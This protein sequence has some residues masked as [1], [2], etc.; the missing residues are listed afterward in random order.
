MG[1]WKL[2]RRHTVR[3][4][5]RKIVETLGG[6]LVGKAFGTFQFHHQRVVDKEIREILSHRMPLIDYG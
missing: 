4:E 1:F 2:T 3:P 5:A 6:V